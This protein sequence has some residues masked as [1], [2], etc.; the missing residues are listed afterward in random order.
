[1]KCAWELHVNISYYAFSKGEC[2]YVK[3]YIFVS[4]PKWFSITVCTHVHFVCTGTRKNCEVFR[5]KLQEGHVRKGVELEGLELGNSKIQWL[6]FKFW[7]WQ[8]HCS[9]GPFKPRIS[10]HN[11]KEWSNTGISSGRCIDDSVRGLC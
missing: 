1:M 9:W 8:Q 3:C 7:C 6:S 5:V 10:V 11:W 2:C 4:K